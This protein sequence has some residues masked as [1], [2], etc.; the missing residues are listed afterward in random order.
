MLECAQAEELDVLVEG[1]REA[2]VGGMPWREMAVLARTRA[3]A[4]DPLWVGG[5]EGACRCLWLGFIGAAQVGDRW[6]L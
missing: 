6:S 2:H 4:S 5:I 1:L 3:A